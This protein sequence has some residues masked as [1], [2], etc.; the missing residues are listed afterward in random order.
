ME[1]ASKHIV[2]QRVLAHS[3]FSFQMEPLSIAVPT[4]AVKISGGVDRVILGHLQ[5]PATGELIY[6]EY[7]P[8]TPPYTN[9]PHLSICVYDDPQNLPSVLRSL[10]LAECRET[11]ASSQNRV[12]PPCPGAA[13]VASFRF[14]AVRFNAGFVGTIMNAV[15][16]D[17]WKKWYK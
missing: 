16:S 2:T 15:E 4:S 8:Y 5:D 10:D 13:I 17:R 3:I 7:F 11:T 14:V 9:T 12:S 6:Y 1:Q